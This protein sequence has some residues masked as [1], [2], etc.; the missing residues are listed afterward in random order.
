MLASITL[1]ITAEINYSQD[2]AKFLI[3]TA[4]V[5]PPPKCPQFIEYLILRK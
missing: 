5:M 4:T 2:T 3:Q 1:Q